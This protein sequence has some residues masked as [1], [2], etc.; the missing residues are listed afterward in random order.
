MIDKVPDSFG[1]V[2]FVFHT[3]EYPFSEIKRVN[4]AKEHY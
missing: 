3:N 2:A 4:I 1:N